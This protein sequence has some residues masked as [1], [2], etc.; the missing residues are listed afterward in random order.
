[1]P[2]HFA[3]HRRETARA[4]ESH[5]L[6]TDA[7]RAGDCSSIQR[8]GSRNRRPS[9]RPRKGPN[10]Q[11]SR[12]QSRAAREDSMTKLYRVLLSSAAALCL[13][14]GGTRAQEVTLS[15]LNFLPNN[16]SFGI[17]FADWVEDANKTGKG[18][19]Q[20]QIKPAGSISPF[21]MG[22]AVK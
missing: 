7:V 10:D 14:A 16:N 21:Q 1:M 22:N 11:N 8:A 12:P 3:G 18:I 2:A 4:T 6:L 19:V 13:A 17:P 5:F 9:G 15:A 20:V